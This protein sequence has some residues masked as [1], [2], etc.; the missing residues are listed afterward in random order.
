MLDIVIAASNIADPVNLQEPRV[1]CPTCL[2]H[3][4]TNWAGLTAVSFVLVKTLLLSNELKEASKERQAL[5]ES[6]N[7]LCASHPLLH[8]NRPRDKMEAAAFGLAMELRSIKR[9]KGWRGGQKPLCLTQG[10]HARL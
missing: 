2:L 9:G 4:E 1:R 10:G 8:P 6:R 5:C 3:V 7:Q